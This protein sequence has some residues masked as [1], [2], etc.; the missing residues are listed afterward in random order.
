MVIIAILI[1]LFVLFFFVRH[2]VG[3]ALL[4]IIAGVSVY[5]M[6]GHDFVNWVHGFLSQVP[7]DIIGS[8]I[9][10]LLIFVL[11]ILLFMRSSHGGLHGLFHIAEAAVV[12][13]LLTVLLMPIVTKYC[14][15][16]TVSSG[17]AKTV[18][19]VRGI[20]VLVGVGLAYFDILLSRRAK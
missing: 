13:T 17:L 14:G 6:F 5:E 18:E 2:H 12:A 8:V 1:A 19:P 10:A 7:V 15:F 11:P 9:Y 16:D 20:I 3:L 4:A